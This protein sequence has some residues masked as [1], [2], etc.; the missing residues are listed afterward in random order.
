MIVDDY[1]G[2]ASVEKLKHRVA[3][4]VASAACDQNV[5]HHRFNRKLNENSEEL[6]NNN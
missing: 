1:D 2:V 6:C 3:T 4:D 5:L